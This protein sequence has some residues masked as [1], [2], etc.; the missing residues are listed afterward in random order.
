MGSGA[1]IFAEESSAALR[2]MAAQCRRPPGIAAATAWLCVGAILLCGPWAGIAL[3][4]AIAGLARFG[5]PARGAAPSAQ[6]AAA[7]HSD[8]ALQD[9]Q[10]QVC[11]DALRRMADAV[12][13][14]LGELLAP[15]GHGAREMRGLADAVASIA[16]RS[17]ENIVSSRAAADDSV[18]AARTLAA[19]TG[20]LETSISKIADQM[21]E[22]TTI[23]AS[24]VAAGADVR[25]AMGQ[26]TAQVRAVGAVTGRI[27]GLARQT[28][29]LALNATI[30]AARAGEAG[31]GF[32]VV[33]GEVKALARQTASL[34]EEIGALIS[35]VE[36]VNH[37]AVEKVIFVEAR[38]QD[39]ET[40]AGRIAE[41]VN[42]QRRATQ[43]IASN[44][45]STA[46]AS[47]TLSS[48]VENLTITMMETLDQTASIHVTASNLVEGAERIEEDLRR[49]ITRAVRTALPEL[50]RRRF[51][52]FPVSAE[53]SG[54]LACTITVG[55]APV[56]VR[57][58]D[59]S[60]GGCQVAAPGTI[61]I[62][63]ETRLHIAAANATY[64]ARI[65]QR[66]AED[67]QV[68]LMLEFDELLDDPAALAA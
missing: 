60:R 52:R 29:L 40:I 16:E 11:R 39:L 31:S 45:H 17:G 15:V 3:C 26:L 44:V 6:A 33:A 59:L 65:V 54:Q 18:D 34:T 46:E 38:I 28:N 27:A 19:A 67:D 20:E 48:Q 58:L 41:E 7:Q 4:A 61:G 9:S 51:A 62:A 35:A 23:S 68:V 56:P 25:G 24:A 21:A 43:S 36:S 47:A 37:D 32:A 14:Q 30:E 5:T 63:T 50:D 1:G 64:A 66:R 57:M 8:I 22:A 53:K 10:E 12:E 13:G 55:D 49:G 42:E 2:A